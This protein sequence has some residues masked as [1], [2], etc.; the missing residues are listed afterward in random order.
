LAQMFELDDVLAPV[1]IQRL[2]QDRLLQ[3]AHDLGA[4]NSPRARRPY[5]PTAS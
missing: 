1:G 2:E 5:G 3:I 4:E